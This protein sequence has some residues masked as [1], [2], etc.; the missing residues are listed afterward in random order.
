MSQNTTIP[1]HIIDQ[2]S[3]IDIVEVVNEY[4]TLKRSGVNWIGLCPF[5]TDKSPSFYVSPSKQ[6]CKCFACG[7]PD[8]G[9]GG[10]I[11]FVEQMENISFPA[12]VRLLAKKYNIDIPEIQLSPEEEA[13]DK[14]RES[15]YIALAAAQQQFEDNYLASQDTQHYISTVRQV[16]EP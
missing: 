4:V 8:K 13:R 9:E 16:S 10:V 5:H 3:D 12:A 7:K 6:I 11:H 1:Q 2:V 14:R 15:L